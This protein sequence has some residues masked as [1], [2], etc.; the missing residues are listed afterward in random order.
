MDLDLS[1]PTARKTRCDGATPCLNCKKRNLNCE[2]QIPSR[3][4]ARRKKA[5]QAAAAAAS[6][7]SPSEAN[8]SVLPSPARSRPSTST[9]SPRDHGDAPSLH[10]QPYSMPSLPPVNDRPP[11]SRST[12]SFS[13]RLPSIAHLVSPTSP[14]EGHQLKSVFKRSLTPEEKTVSPVSPPLPEEPYRQSKRMRLDALV[15][16]PSP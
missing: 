9:G 1:I 16:T 7:R 10:H 6:E 4:A 2:Y 11:S 12:S 5:Q 14:I 13:P 3:E 8:E 15:N